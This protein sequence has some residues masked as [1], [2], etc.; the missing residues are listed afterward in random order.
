M[1]RVTVRCPAKVNLHL[2]VLGARADGYHEVRT[3]LAPVGVWDELVL[4]PAPDGELDLS[5]EPDGA[6][7]AGEANL[8]VRAARA[9]QA[10][11]G[12]QAGARLALHKRIPVAAGLGGGS[13][14]AAGALVGL[15]TLWGLPGG[16]A[17]LRADAAT[18]G[19]DVPCFLLGG[20]VWGVGRGSEVYPLSDLPAWW[21]VLL[22]GEERVSTA[23]VYRALP[24]APAGDAS[25]AGVYD[26]I[27]AGGGFPVMACRNDLEPT[28]AARWPGVARRLAAIRASGPLLALLSGSG[29]TVFGLFQNEEAARREAATLAAFDPLIAPLL[30]RHASL[31]RPSAEE[32]PWTSPTYGS[33]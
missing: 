31:L 15:A 33:T 11:F 20:V 32:G 13:A 14:D 12:I 3:V 30:S 7:P 25:L 10:R 27:V 18:L 2:E 4:E 26:W 8:V 24:A 6:V 1:R 16:F 28:V 9:L 19:T 29:G 23:E 17:D 5:V 21:A 22:P